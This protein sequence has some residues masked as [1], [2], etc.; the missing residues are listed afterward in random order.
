MAI[1]CRYAFLT[2]IMVGKRIRDRIAYLLMA[3]QI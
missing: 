3:L 2:K 1:I